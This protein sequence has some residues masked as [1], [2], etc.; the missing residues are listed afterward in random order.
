MNFAAKNA[1]KFNVSSDSDDKDSEDNSLIL[2]IL[3]SRIEREVIEE[4]N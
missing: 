2:E 3:K 1:A 4:L